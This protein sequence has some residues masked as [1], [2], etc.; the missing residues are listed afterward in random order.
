MTAHS[1]KHLTTMEN[2]GMGRGAFTQAAVSPRSIL[3]DIGRDWLVGCQ[4]YVL[5]ADE[6]PAAPK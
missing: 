5:H 3:R 1:Q 4:Y 6:A 2:E